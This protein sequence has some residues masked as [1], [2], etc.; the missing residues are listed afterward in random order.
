MEVDYLY[1]AANYILINSI[2]KNEQVRKRVC[3][4]L[5]T[6]ISMNKMKIMFVFSI[7]L[8]TLLQQISGNSLES[9]KCWT[10]YTPTYHYGTAHCYNAYTRMTKPCNIPEPPRC[11]CRE[12]SIIAIMLNAEGTWCYGGVENKWPCENVDEW[13]SVLKIEQVPKRVHSHFFTVIIMKIMFVSSMLLIILFQQISADTLENCKC[14]TN[15]V[16]ADFQGAAECHNVL[17]RMTQ[18]CN[19]PEPPRCQCKE[20]SII[21]IMTDVEGTWCYGG[22]GNKWPCENVDE[23]NRYEKECKN[24][25]HCI[26]NSNKAN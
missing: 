2:L 15:Y 21:G 24:D 25:I 8:I 13:N 14:W 11:Q 22:E 18:P 1:K 17:T 7:L 4:H 10:N 26:P 23:W 12:G 16:P 20:G 3:S 5:F 9:C 19:I 6:L